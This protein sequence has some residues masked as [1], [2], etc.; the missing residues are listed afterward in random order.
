[1]PNW[2]PSLNA[3]RALEALSR[4]NSYRAAA[5]EL[6]VTPAAIKQLVTKL[7]ESLGKKLVER[8]GRGI[9]LTEA[10]KIA[11]PDLNLGMRHLTDAVHKMRSPIETERLIISVEAS[12]AT[13]WLVPRLENFR[14][15]NPNI[16]VLIDSSQRIVDLTR[17]DV[18]IAIRYGVTNPAGLVVLRLFDDLVH[19]ACSPSM[20]RQLPALSSLDQLADVPLIHWDMSRLPWAKETVKWFDWSEW[21]KRAGLPALDT[22]R[23]LRFNDYG[24]AIQAAISGQGFVLASWPI[25][26]DQLDAGLLVKPFQNSALKTGIGYDLVTTQQARTRPA[27]ATFCNW[28]QQHAATTQTRSHSPPLA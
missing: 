24:L 5:E 17:S 10:A 21:A 12:L 16:N 9:A 26:Q 6:R 18:D 3:L 13:T 20:A 2:L 28:I 4:C 11:T 25:L 23:G 1:M 19:P 7:E 14:A 22:T 15:V 8:Q 27:V